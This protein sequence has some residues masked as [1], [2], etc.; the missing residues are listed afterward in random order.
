MPAYNAE[1]TISKAIQSVLEQSYKD[2]ELIIVNDGSTDSTEDIV[3]SWRLRDS[4][5]KN[6]SIS[7]GGVSNARNIALSNSSGEFVA[8][9]DADDEMEAGFIEKMINKMSDECDLVCC[10]YNIISNTGEYLF[11]LEVDEGKYDLRNYY[12]GIELLQEQ[13]LFNW[14]CNKLFRL[15]IIKENDIL[16]DPAVKMGE[17]FLFVVDYIT[18]MKGLLYCIPN[19]LYRYT[20]SPTGA[21]AKLNKNDTIEKRIERINHLVPLYKREDYPMDS[22]YDEQLRYIYSSL[23]D[24]SFKKEE[25]AN[26]FRI[27]GIEKLDNYKPGQ[28]KM[29]L[30]KALLFSRNLALISMFIMLFAYIK[31][32]IGKSYKWG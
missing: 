14:L 29:R 18:N 22:I 11:G 24:N 25:L 7:N 23:R 16:L 10:G 27:D 30:F 6:I 13:K 19:K 5:I 15:S 8:F 17:D 9:I 2:F 4:R 21:Q 3:L 1:K 32:I 12:K 20:L 31:R 26:L 28:L